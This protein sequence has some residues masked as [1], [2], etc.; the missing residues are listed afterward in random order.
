MNLHVGGEFE[1]GAW[2][3]SFGPSAIVLSPDRLRRRLEANLKMMI[4]SYRTEVTIAPSPR[5]DR[6][7]TKKVGARR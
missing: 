1:L 2:I 4:D 5:A 7:A 6:K 3:L